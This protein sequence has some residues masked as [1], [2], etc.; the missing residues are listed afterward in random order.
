MIKLHQIGLNPD[1]EKRDVF[2]KLGIGLPEPAGK[3]TSS[4]TLTLDERS[5]EYQKLQPYVKKWNLSDFIAVTFSDVELDKATYLVML[6]PWANDYPM[7]DNDGG[8]LQRTYD[9]TNYCKSCG[10]GLVQRE[11]FRL[12][13]E[14]VWGKKKLFSLNWVYDEYFVNKDF[15]EQVLNKYRIETMPVL[16]YKKDSVIESTVQIKISVTSPALKLEGRSFITC[17]ACGRKR[18]DLINDDFFPSFEDP[19]PQSAIFK[20]LEDFGTGA[21]TRKYVFV[22]Q[23]LRKEFQT[24]GVKPRFLPVLGYLEAGDEGFE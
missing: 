24:A 13:K 14:P 20:G 8:Y 19:Q 21:N 15:Y 22:S 6:S 23:A 12:K 4:V 5:D 17:E 18:Y 2:R 16:L 11:P 9:D 1:Q 3:L 7:P 10:S